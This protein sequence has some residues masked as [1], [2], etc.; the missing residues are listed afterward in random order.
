MKPRKRGRAIGNSTVIDLHTHSVFSDGTQT[1]EQL[2]AEAEALGLT[3]LALT[4]HDTVAGLP[5][6]AAAGEGA[7]VRT[8][9][10]VEISADV[11]KGT[12]HML[13]YF[14]D[15]ACERL[16]TALVEIREGRKLRNERILKRLNELGMELTWDEVIAYAGDEVISRPHFALA[17]EARGY[18]KSKKEAFDRHL[19]K[20]K[21]G[22]VERFR[23]P[24]EEGIA[25]IREAGGVAALAHPRTLELDAAALRERLIAWKEQGLGGV[26]VY[27]SE[28][29]AE[30]TAFYLS[31]TR[32]L[33]L[34]AVGGSDYHGIVTPNLRLGTG[35]GT[36]RVPGEA[37]EALE[38]RRV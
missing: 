4:D 6:F 26:E 16:N 23:L 27:Y 1:P 20:G 36:L 17:M 38:S 12:M 28:H 7:T 11:V 9:P 35:F 18:V 14:V 15:A 10:G 21:P 33:G 29:S 30:Q 2:V 13:G 5:R 32:E 34:V 37:L 3:A 25:L 19:A 24:P 8:V 22:Y 31:L